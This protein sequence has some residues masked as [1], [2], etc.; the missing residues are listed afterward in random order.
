[1]HKSILGYKCSLYKILYFF[2]FFFINEKRLSYSKNGI[3][4]QIWN[5]RS[6]D[7]EQYNIYI[8]VKVI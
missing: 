7:W 4:C 1:M 5:F 8:K 6:W 2:Q 3:Q